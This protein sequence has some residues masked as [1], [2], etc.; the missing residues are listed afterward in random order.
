MLFGRS[1]G[2]AIQMSCRDVTRKV[3]MQ[4]ESGL[5]ISVAAVCICAVFV[6]TK[7]S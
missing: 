6:P 3:G 2:F 1:F 5:R 4:V 7:A